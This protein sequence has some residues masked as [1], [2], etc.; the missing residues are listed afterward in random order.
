MEDDT[1]DELA[2][3][4]QEAIVQEAESVKKFTEVLRE[5]Y[6]EYFP[7]LRDQIAPALGLRPTQVHQVLYDYRAPV[8]KHKLKR[9]VFK[10]QRAKLRKA[11]VMRRH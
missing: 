8:P 4:A 6:D 1:P 10:R 9:S 7:E 5:R 2:Q 11:I 3:Q